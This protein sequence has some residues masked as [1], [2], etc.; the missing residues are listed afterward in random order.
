MKE[1]PVMGLPRL[2]SQS[3]VALGTELSQLQDGV[4]RAISYDSY[5]LTSEQRRYCTTRLEL[6][7]VVKFT[8]QYRHYLLGRT[9]VVRIDHSSLQWLMNFKE[10]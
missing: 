4:Q 6:L 10:P 7:A 1:A 2:T 3:D 9:F 8:S 5:G